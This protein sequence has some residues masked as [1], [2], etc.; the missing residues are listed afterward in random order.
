[1]PLSKK[2]VRDKETARQRILQNFPRSENREADFWMMKNDDLRTVIELCH[3]ASER[4]VAPS[5]GPSPEPGWEE[6]A[7]IAAW[8]VA[9]LLEELLWRRKNAL[10]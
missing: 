5:T 1:M 4:D 3:R 2:Q 9:K 6:Q 10:K 8:E 7:P